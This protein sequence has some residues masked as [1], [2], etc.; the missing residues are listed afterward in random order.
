MLTTLPNGVGSFKPCVSLA[1]N[2]RDEP[3]RRF[4][5]IESVKQYVRGEL[6]FVMQTVRGYR[7]FVS[8]HMTNIERV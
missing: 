4:G 8:S 5:R 1:F 2:Y 3:M 7:S 6:L